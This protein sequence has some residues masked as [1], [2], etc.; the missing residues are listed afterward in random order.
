[1]NDLIENSA[2]GTRIELT[3][4]LRLKRISEA[5]NCDATLAEEVWN[6]LNLDRFDDPADLNDIR[7]AV[8]SYDSAIKHLKR[9]IK[10]LEGL[11]VSEED[12]LLVARN[13]LIKASIKTLRDLNDELVSLHAHRQS[14]L[15]RN[16]S[17][18]GSDP[19][20]DLLAELVAVIF[21]KTNRKVAFGL[22]DKEPSTLFC[23]AVKDVL[24]IC[25][26]KRSVKNDNAKISSWRQP[27]RKAFE[28]RRLN[29]N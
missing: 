3:L 13:G 21:E 17:A 23:K 14:V 7:E 9:L 1:M 24:L 19:R 29:A 11:P 27:A 10:L 26:N 28:S 4:N 6:N 5:L 15:D 2:G 22:L 18:G 12:R 25:D 20:A 8:A 16:P